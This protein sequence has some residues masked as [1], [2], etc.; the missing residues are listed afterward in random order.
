MI[1]L[2][3][4][5]TGAAPER[6]GADFHAARDCRSGAERSDPAAPV[7]P[8]RPERPAPLRS[9]APF[10][11]MFCAELKVIHFGALLHHL[12]SSYPSEFAQSVIVF[13]TVRRH[14]ER[15][16][17]R[18]GAAKGSCCR[19][20][21]AEVMQKCSKMATSAQNLKD[22]CCRDDAKVLQNDHF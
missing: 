5:R 20:A 21:A 22:S 9:S 7:A 1:L 15:P 16:S 12:C 18:I 11:T 17:V 6:S 2:S 10:A 8:E 14:F 13:G 19:I 3:I 4:A